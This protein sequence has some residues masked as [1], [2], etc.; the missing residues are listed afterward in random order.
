M[1]KY[2]SLVN[3]TCVHF[4]FEYNSEALL[5]CAD[6]TMSLNSH[7][8]VFLTCLSGWSYLS[9]GELSVKPG[10]CHNIDLCT[11]PTDRKS[12]FLL[13]PFLIH[14]ASIFFQSSSHNTTI[15]MN[16]KPGFYLS[17]LSPLCNFSINWCLVIFRLLLFLT[18][19][20]MLRCLVLSIFFIG[21]TENAKNPPNKNCVSSSKR[22]VVWTLAYLGVKIV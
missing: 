20:S 14:S 1:H 17:F 13:P 16:N 22:S 9:P 2:A 5:G 4:S 11:S 8:V 15:L 18:E 3:K 10:L 7:G 6:Q 21:Y 12:A 19:E